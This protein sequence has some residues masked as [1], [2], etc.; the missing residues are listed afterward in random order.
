[1]I[2]ILHH[3]VEAGVENARFF[4]SGSVRNGKINIKKIFSSIV[5]IRNDCIMISYGKE[6]CGED[7]SIFDCFPTMVLDKLGMAAVCTAASGAAF[8]LERDDILAASVSFPDFRICFCFSAVSGQDE[9]FV[10]DPDVSSPAAD[11]H[12]RRACSDLMRSGM[13]SD[14]SGVAESPDPVLVSGGQRTEC[15][16][17]HLD[18]MRMGGLAS[19]G[20]L[21]L[22]EGDNSAAFDHPFF[23]Y[24]SD[25][26]R[27]MV[28]CPRF[29]DD[30]GDQLRKVC[31]AI[32]QNGVFAESNP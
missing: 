14:D 1:M 9:T 12:S 30:P 13:E 26:A 16:A 22:L 25:F 7:E 6:G 20:S 3:S 32:C 24:S 17:D 31:S 10:A 29:P 8:S 19:V 28:P 2:R 15:S 23:Q 27:V 5:F 4:L 11:L 21:Y 18:R